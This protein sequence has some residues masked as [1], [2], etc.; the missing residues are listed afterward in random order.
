MENMPP[1]KLLLKNPE[2]DNYTYIPIKS[3]FIYQNLG[4]NLVLPKKLDTPF[5]FSCFALSIDGKLSYPDAPSGFNIA[6]ANHTAIQNEKT[7]DLF[8]LMLARTISDAIII[9]TNS[10][11]EENG[12]YLPQIIVRDLHQ[13]RMDNGKPILPWTIILC[14]SLDKINFNQ[15]LFKDEQ[16]PL[17]IGCFE[18]QDMLQ[19]TPQNYTLTNLSNLSNR[20]QLTTKNIVI[21]D[22]SF[23]QLFKTLKQLEFNIILNESPFFHHQFLEHKLLDEIW[24]NYSCSYIGGD[25]VASLGKNQQAFSSITHP[26]TEI[27]TLHHLDYHFLYSRQKV[28]YA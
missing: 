16:F 18:P 6:Q 7:A 8:Y 21:I 17:L 2:L 14:R 9:G 25:N 22:S 20:E 28:L 19:S 3:N 27:L 5:L 12:T 4:L 1:L 23:R 10:L 13:A 11:R 24:L 26:D 15:Q